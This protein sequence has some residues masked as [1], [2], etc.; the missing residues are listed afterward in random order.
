M[1]KKTGKART[2]NLLVGALRE[3]VG[4]LGLLSLFVVDAQIPL[5]VFGK[6]MEANEVIFFVCRRPVLAPCITVVEQDSSLADKL[7]GMFIGSAVECHSHGYLLFEVLRIV[8][9][10]AGGRF[11]AGGGLVAD[12]A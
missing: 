12:N 2:A 8:S 1:P 7:P 4:P 5:A 9:A 3:F 10:S 11:A 6:T